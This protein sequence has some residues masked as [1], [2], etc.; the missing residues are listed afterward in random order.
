M[1]P[2]EAGTQV[3][4]EAQSAPKAEQEAQKKPVRKKA[5]RG[6]RKIVVTKSKRKEAVARATARLGGGII[7]INGRNAG[8]LEPA[9]LRARV[10]EPVN[11][12]DITS[13]LAAKLDVDVNVS[14]GGA[15]SQAQAARGAIAR[16]M[17][18]FSDTDT[19]RKEYLRYDR[20]LLVDDP[21][22]V[23]PKKF[24]GPK[25]RARFQ[26]SYR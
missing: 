20:A 22:R 3:M 9:E 19:I 12:S 1:M 21:R 2:T 24:K 6:E 7:R 18:A 8:T 5:K 10:L 25:A 15:V 26:K 14:G 13:D 11:L 16:A 4:V 23:E 17:V